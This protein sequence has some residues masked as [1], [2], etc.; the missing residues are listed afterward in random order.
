MVKIPCYTARAHHCAV[1]CLL[2]RLFDK[3]RYYK[4]PSHSQGITVIMEQPGN[5][6]H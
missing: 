4:V 3:N 6:Y 2:L 5:L 1:L